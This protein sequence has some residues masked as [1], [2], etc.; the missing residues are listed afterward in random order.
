MNIIV[1]G[2]TG[3]IGR[4]ILPNLIEAGHTVTAITRSP[5]RAAQIRAA[6]ALP[7]VCDIFDQ[8][9]LQ[10]VVLDAKPEVVIHELTNIPQ[11]IDARH[12]SRDFAQTNRLRTE[13]T[14][15]LMQAARAA[16]ARRFLA[17]SIA[18]YYT[19]NSALLATEEVPLY[20]EAPSAFVEIVQAIDDLEQIVLNTPGMD[21]IVLRYGYLYGPGTAH[22]AEGSFTEDVR[23]RR[24]PIIGGGRAV[25]SFIHVADAAAATVL[26][27]NRGEPGIYNIVDDDPASLREWLPIYAE[28]CGAPRPMQV[29]KFVGRLV[30]GRFGVYFMTEQRGASNTK[31]KQ[32]LAWQLRYPSWRNGFCAELTPTGP[33]ASDTWKPG[34]DQPLHGLGE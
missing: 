6:G 3:V 19:P 23:H 31:A 21:G 15:I 30:A 13:G 11:H 25:F 24:I 29:P 5:D 22:A 20:K 32:V 14:R 34:A 1:A 2:A 4:Q 26:A 17:Q 28:V 12:V 7:V 27:M 33:K 8:D 18:T 10:K 16:G 9:R